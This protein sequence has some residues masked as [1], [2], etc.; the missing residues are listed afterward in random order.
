MSIASGVLTC[1]SYG[2]F[3][4]VIENNNEYNQKIEQQGTV[5]YNAYLPNIILAFYTNIYYIQFF[6]ID[7]FN[8][9]IMCSKLNNVFPNNISLYILVFW[10]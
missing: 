8:K 6:Y 2:W 4:K 10:A 5:K 9:S 3:A 7:T 1:D